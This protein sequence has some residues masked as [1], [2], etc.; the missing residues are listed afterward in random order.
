MTMATLTQLL[1]G[2]KQQDP[3]I[4]EIISCPTDPTSPTG[5]EGYF[6]VRAG[7]DQYKKVIEYF[8]VLVKD[9]G[10]ATEAAYL[11][12][13]LQGLTAAKTPTAFETW[14]DNRIATELA[15]DPTIEKIIKEY[16]DTVQER[17]QLLVVKTTATGI[18]KI[19]AFVYTD[20]A[21]TRKVH[22]ENL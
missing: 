2:L 16:I 19:I 15:G 7:A 22:Y 13:Q 14:L 5:M 1:N 12:T 9:K 10:Q 17:A 6:S 3:T 11:I 8:Q 21:G 20:R 4:Q 18:K